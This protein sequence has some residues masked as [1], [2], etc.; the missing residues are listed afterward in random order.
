MA[1]AAPQRRAFC[2]VDE[3]GERTITVLGEKLRPSGGD[4]RL[5]WHELAGMEAVFFVSGDAEAVRLA[6]SARVLVATARELPTL[7]A[8]G[9]QLDVIVGSGEDEGELYHPGELDPA[10]TL[11]VTTAARL[12]GWARPGGP[13]RPAPLPGPVAD[14]YG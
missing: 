1:D 7:R 12:G 5:P 14:T 4:S 8:A 9:V 3:V 6:R 11:V 10:P 2:F 13:F